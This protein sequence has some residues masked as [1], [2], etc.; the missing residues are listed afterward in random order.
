MLFIDTLLADLQSTTVGLKRRHNF[1][2][3]GSSTDGVES[4]SHLT[5]ASHLS[6]DLL[7][8]EGQVS[9]TR[10][11]LVAI[12]SSRTGEFRIWQVSLAEPCQGFV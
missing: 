5:M 4:D 6:T 7:D 2:A 1:T 9:V 3:D 10:K 12:V 8:A 11:L